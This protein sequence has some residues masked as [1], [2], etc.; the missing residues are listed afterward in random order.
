MASRT[1]LTVMAHPDDAELTCAGSIARWVRE[2]GRAVLV[3]ATDGSR[4]G[5]HP[6]PNLSGEAMARTRRSEQIEAAALIGFAEIVSLGFG[7]G[8][9]QEDDA[10]RGALVEQ[11]R[12][13]R[14][15][16]A[17]AMDPLTVIYRD[18]YINHRDHRV[19]GMALLDAL[20][21]QASNA[22]YFPEQLERGLQPHKVP[23][24][25][26]A[27]S[28]HPN[29]W[30]DVTDTI[31][32]RFDA[33]RCHR[34]QIRLWPENGEAIIRQQRDYAGVIGTEHGMTYAEAFRRVVVDPLS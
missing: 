20:Y 16:T 12:K 9:L 28:E 5:K 33:L 6:E 1:I 29:F 18:S 7:D 32:I 14:P 11:I 30:V 8:E 10:L 27:N 4:G 3:I 34:S 26:L 19:L 25:L 21:P 2:G 15:Q 13:W 31:D 22:G 24:L 17:V 23:E